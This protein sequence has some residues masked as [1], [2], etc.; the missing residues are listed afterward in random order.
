MLLGLAFALAACDPCSGLDAEPSI[1]P[2]SPAPAQV[3]IAITTEALSGLAAV[4][5]PLTRGTRRVRK[6]DV[7]GEARTL[8][9]TAGNRS[10]LLMDDTHAA[11]DCGACAILQVRMDFELATGPSPLVAEPNRVL[12]E[13]RATI[14]VPVR[15]E[16]T[17]PVGTP[18]AW[19]LAAVH[20]GR[21]ETVVAPPQIQEGLDPAVNDAITALTEEVAKFDATK[22]TGKPLLRLQGWTVSDPGLAFVPPTVR[23]EGRL[24][25]LEA[26]PAGP[27]RGTGLTDVEVEP[28]IGQDLTWAV[29]PAYLAAL[30]DDAGSE[31]GTVQVG[32]AGHDLEVRSIGGSSK[33]VSVALRARRSEGCGWVDLDAD[34]LRG[35]GDGTGGIKVVGGSDV[36]VVSTGGASEEHAA[37][38]GFHASAERRAR[39]QLQ[40]RLDHPL[41]LGPV[42]QAPTVVI[43]RHDPEGAVLADATFPSRPR[44]TPVRRPMPEDFSKLPTIKFPEE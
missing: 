10:A 43:V 14:R 36:S 16:L 1:A 40:E 15:L 34:K 35:T 27:L 6:I 39:E 7:G 18:G 20:D 44:R 29:A 19:E 42:G 41:V 23:A 31:R 37:D 8:V 26:A 3:R 33:G 25:V 9:A 24:V 2:Q 13:A 21:R 38:L 5:R 28:G 12:G 17:S 30:A 11:S 32:G 4:Q 22:M